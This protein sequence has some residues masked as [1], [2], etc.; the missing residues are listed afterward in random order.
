VGTVWLSATSQLVDRLGHESLSFVVSGFAFGARSAQEK[1]LW[2]RAIGNIQ[3]KLAC[4]PADSSD[5][6]ICIYRAA[7]AEQLNIIEEDQEFAELDVAPVLQRA[8]I[9]CSLV[10]GDLDDVGLC[11]DN[12]FLRPCSPPAAVES[13]AVKA[14]MD[15]SDE[16]HT[17]VPDLSV[18]PGAPWNCCQ[19]G[20]YNY[21]AVYHIAMPLSPELSVCAGRYDL[22][23]QSKLANGFPLYR[24][25]K[26]EYSLFSDGE[27]WTIGIWPDA[28]GP[29]YSIGVIRPLHRHDG[30]PPFSMP[31]QGWACRNCLPD[32]DSAEA[33][34]KSSWLGALSED[35]AVEFRNLQEEVERV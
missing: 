8:A 1:Q 23:S 15:S 4:G 32:L 6:D 9:N 7:L 17:H 20:G 26:G 31:R 22:L 25:V 19:C 35:E 34:A 3:V 11:D 14:S 33:M 29:G 28:R 27:R 10:L 12:D 21:P 5:A 24:H 13:K 16:V 2:V 18:E 30:R